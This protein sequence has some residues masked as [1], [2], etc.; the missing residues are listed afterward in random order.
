MVLRW[1]SVETPCNEM[2]SLKK[3]NISIKSLK[4]VLHCY[5]S[6]FKMITCHA[7]QHDPNKILDQGH[8]RYVKKY[9]TC[10]SESHY[11]MKVLEFKKKS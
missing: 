6:C 5:Y 1:D 9:G 10:I 7:V 3:R 4:P 11:V 2:N 8:D